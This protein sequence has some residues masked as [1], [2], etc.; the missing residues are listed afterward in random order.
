MF[1]DRLFDTIMSEMMAAFG[2][3]VRTDEG[4]LAF[5]ACAKIAEKLEE[6]YGDMDEIN[7]NLL[8][9]TQDDSHLIAYGSERGLE[10]S[11]ATAPVVRGVFKQSIEEGE[12]F[13]CGDYTYTVTGQI[14]EWEYR[15]LCDTEGTYAN[16]ALGALE[17]LDY[18][19]DYQGGEITEVMVICMC[20]H[21]T[22]RTALTTQNLWSGPMEIKTTRTG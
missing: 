11:Y 14:K 2:A 1:D 17:P 18:I 12:R 22:T 13:T 3:D 7:D 10:Y 20:L 9:D 8:P 21:P 15:L 6:V 5:N 16:A 4:S 19:D